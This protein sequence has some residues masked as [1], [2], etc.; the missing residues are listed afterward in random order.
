MRN[1]II[2]GGATYGSSV[3]RKQLRD[4]TLLLEQ[5]VPVIIDLMMDGKNEV[6]GDPVYPVT[7]K[8]DLKIQP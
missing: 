5:I 6:W 8:D 4:C 3:N 7:I 1:Q 2:H